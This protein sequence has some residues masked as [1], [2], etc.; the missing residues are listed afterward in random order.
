M[1]DDKYY[2]YSKLNS[3][4]PYQPGKSK[5]TQFSK[6]TL[7]DKANENAVQRRNDLAQVKDKTAQAQKL[8]AA[9]QVIAKS[10]AQ[11]LAGGVANLD[12]ALSGMVG[13][14]ISKKV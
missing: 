8:G 11:T 12:S 14:K 10:A 9:K 2:D 4:S 1:A 5:S 13:T 3:V 7:N 6:N